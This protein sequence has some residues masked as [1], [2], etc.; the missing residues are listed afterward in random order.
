MRTNRL[1]YY[2]AV[3]VLVLVAALSEA[4]PA[5]AE[6]MFFDP[7]TPT[8]IPG[9]ALNDSV[10]WS[11]FDVNNPSVVS[12]NGITVTVQAQGGPNFT[13]GPTTSSGST[14]L[15][16]TASGSSTVPS[17]LAEITLDFSQPVSKVF[18]HLSAAD[19]SIAGLGAGGAYDGITVYDA[20]GDSQTF[21]TGVIDN[22]TFM[23]I[24]SDTANISKLTFDDYGTFPQSAYEAIGNLELSDSPSGSS[25]PAPSGLFLASHGA[26]VL[27]GYG[28]WRRCRL[29]CA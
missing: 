23:A 13:F 12:T 16:A 4:T 29:A 11:G 5:R 19:S 1:V 27:L 7:A 15:V 22:D 14:Y 17:S 20:I 21:G 6:F 10:N 28:C 25:V 26:L 3:L 9:P 2:R 24:V 18:F 8:T